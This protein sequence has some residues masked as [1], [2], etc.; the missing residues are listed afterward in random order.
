MIPNLT[1]RL[2]RLNNTTKSMLITNLNSKFNIPIQ[3]LQK[4]SKE[5]LINMQRNFDMNLTIQIKNYQ[6]IS[7]QNRGFRRI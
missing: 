5:E 7:Q 3:T 6:F 2:S 4:L 1:P